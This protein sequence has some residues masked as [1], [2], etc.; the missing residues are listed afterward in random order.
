MT[1]RIA[2]AHQAPKLFQKFLEFSG[3]IRE[4]GI[5]QAIYDLVDIRA[6]Q[7]NGCA[8]CLD[9]HVKEA[10]IHGERE[11]GLYHISVWRETPPF[12]G[13]ERTAPGRTGRG[14]QN[15]EGGLGRLF[16][17]GGGEISGKEKM[18]RRGWD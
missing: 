10:K 6:S 1:Q 12:S 2:Y 13:K 15:F 14:A 16:E 11:L 18:E 3:A 8:F 7:V 9:M 5:D 4:A 17:K